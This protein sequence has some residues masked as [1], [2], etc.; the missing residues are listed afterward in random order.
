M[1]WISV[2]DKLPEKDTPVLIYCKGG[3]T[4]VAEKKVVRWPDEEETHWIV[5]GP[6]GAGRKIATGRITHWAKLP[7]LPNEG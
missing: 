6:L 7:A 4:F 2:K 1:E 3:S 5:R